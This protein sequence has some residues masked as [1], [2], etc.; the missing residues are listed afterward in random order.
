M[1][2]KHIYAGAGALLLALSIAGCGYGSGAMN[3]AP[4]PAVMQLMPTSVMHGS[5]T[6]SMTVNGTNFAADA[7]VYFNGNVLPTAYGSTTQVTAQVPSADVAA[8]AMVNVYVRSN[9]Q[10]SNMV[11]FT[12]Q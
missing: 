10:N 12:I 6:F 3:G 8:S 7:V 4:A 5:P 1:F 9:G 2:R 11:I